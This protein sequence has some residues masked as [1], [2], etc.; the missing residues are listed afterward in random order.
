MVL[1]GEESV[2]SFR[3]IGWTETTVDVDY[4]TGPMSGLDKAR[5]YAEANRSALKT[6]IAKAKAHTLS[7]SEAQELMYAYAVLLGD[8]IQ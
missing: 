6:L 3:C 7:N 1:G 4:E 8:L 2:M 5:R